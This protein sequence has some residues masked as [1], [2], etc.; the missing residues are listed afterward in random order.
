MDGL[1]LPEHLVQIHGPVFGHP[2]PPGAQLRVGQG[3]PIGHFRQPRQRV[4]IQLDE[5]AGAQP[6]IFLVLP[7]A[8]QHPAELVDIQAAHVKIQQQIAV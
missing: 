5:G 2:D 8:V 4:V 7:V 3:E 6:V 1:L